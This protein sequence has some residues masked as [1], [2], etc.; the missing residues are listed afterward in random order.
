MSELPICD[1]VNDR[2]LEPEIFIPGLLV[3][4]VL[5]VI[6]VP[7]SSDHG[8]DRMVMG[9]LEGINERMKETLKDRDM[10]PISINE[11]HVE[12]MT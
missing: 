6:A 1:E 11:R 3:L 5:E 9:V 2:D 12:I 4:L 7:E 10:N 8:N